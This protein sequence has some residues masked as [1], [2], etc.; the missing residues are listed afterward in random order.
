MIDS[1]TITSQTPSQAPQSDNVRKCPVLSGPTDLPQEP[2]LSPD[3][4]TTCDQTASFPDQTS[5]TP[6][7]PA[8]PPLDQMPQSNL[9]PLTPRDLQ[10]QAAHASP[11]TATA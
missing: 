8:V 2:N 4:Q 9:H 7:P 1:A 6:Q 11:Q 3:H 10:E 5:T